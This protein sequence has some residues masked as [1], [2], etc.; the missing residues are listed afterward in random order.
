[1]MTAVVGGLAVETDAAGRVQLR[2]SLDAPLHPLGAGDGTA[3]GAAYAAAYV[4]AALVKRHVSGEGSYIDMSAAEAVANNGWVTITN[5]VNAERIADRSTMPVTGGRDGAKYQFYETKDERYVL[6]CAIEH[7]FWDRFCRAV[8]RDD[9]AARKDTSAP[10][11]FAPGD[12]DL[13]GEVQSIFHERTLDEWMALAERENLPIGPIVV[14]ASELRSDPH[15][16]ARGLLVEGTHPHAGPFT[17]LREA[18][19]V[20]EDP[21]RVRHPAPLLGEHT[22]EILGELGYSPA[23]LDELRAAGAI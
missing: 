9:L 6:F 16:T 2:S 1:M 14:D 3:T 4:G 8:G 11:D 18:G 5:Q 13:R 12:A 20:G 17:Y 7:K 19:I 23:S 10:V 21:Y 22:D 15:L